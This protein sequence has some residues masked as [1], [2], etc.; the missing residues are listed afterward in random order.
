MSVRRYAEQGARK[1][2]QPV[3]T[4]IMHWLVGGDQHR[5]SSLDSAF[6]HRASAYSALIHES[7]RRA[8]A[9]ESVA[10]RSLD[11]RSAAA[12]QHCYLWRDRRSD[13][14]EIDSRALQSCG[15]WRIAARGRDHWLRAPAEKR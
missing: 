7:F 3:S 12:V 13:T 10:R 15:R 14:Q 5:E 6:A 11:A 2:K 9:D 4:K 1:R 8:A